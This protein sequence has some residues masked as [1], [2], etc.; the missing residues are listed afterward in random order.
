MLFEYER[1]RHGVGIEEDGVMGDDAVRPGEGLAPSGEAPV[2]RTRKAWVKPQ[3][4]RESLKDALSGG[5]GNEDV[6]SSS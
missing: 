6:S 2:A 5:S 1:D 3:F 4:E